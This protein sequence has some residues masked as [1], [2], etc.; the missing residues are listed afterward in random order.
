M[1]EKSGSFVDPNSN[2]F[3]INLHISRLHHKKQFYVQMKYRQLLS[4]QELTDQ[5]LLKSEFAQ[6]QRETVASVD[7]ANSPLV[8]SPIMTFVKDRA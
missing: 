7:D 6:R 3:T 2:N 4:P 8:F 1:C 5:A